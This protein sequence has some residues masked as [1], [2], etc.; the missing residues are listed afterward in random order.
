MKRQQPLGQG[1]LHALQRGP[2]C[3]SC[4]ATNK[5]SLIARE[6]ISGPPLYHTIH[7]CFVVQSSIPKGIFRFCLIS[8]PSYAISFQTLQYLQ[9]S[10]PEEI[11]KRMSQ[12]VLVLTF[13]TRTPECTSICTR[14]L[15]QEWFSCHWD[16]LHVLSVRYWRVGTYGC[17]RNICIRASLLHLSWRCGCCSPKL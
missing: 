17:F 15:K 4:V 8:F 7:A 9:V 3:G 12:P 6:C 1:L 13:V 5:I 14:K 10:L 11:L 16:I 2:I